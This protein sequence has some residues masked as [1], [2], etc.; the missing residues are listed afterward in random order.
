[1]EE[2]VD[3]VFTFWVRLDRR[4]SLFLFMYSITSSSGGRSECCKME[5]F[6]RFTEGVSSRAANP[7]VMAR[8][9]V[10]FSNFFA[11]FGF[12]LIFSENLEK[13]FFVHASKTNLCTS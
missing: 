9:T 1:M 5:L 4:S 7:A 3:L 11:S 8:R 12:L 13:V 10:F 6:F 2:R